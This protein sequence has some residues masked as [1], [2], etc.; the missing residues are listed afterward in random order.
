[1]WSGMVLCDLRKVIEAGTSKPWKCRGL[2]DKSWKHFMGIN[3]DT[4]VVEA[5]GS[6][7]K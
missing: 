3:G 6:R 1:M 5:E 2:L 7:W 4:N